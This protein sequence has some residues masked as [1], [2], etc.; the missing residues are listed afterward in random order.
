MPGQYIP[1]GY[2]QNMLRSRPGP[3]SIRHGVPSMFLTVL[4]S[5]AG[6]VCAPE[7]S[8]PAQ[9]LFSLLL[10]LRAPNMLWLHNLQM[11]MIHSC[12][13]IRHALRCPAASTEIAR[14]SAASEVLKIQHRERGGHQ[15]NPG[16]AGG[17]FLEAGTGGCLERNPIRGWS[18]PGGWRSGRGWPFHGCRAS[19]SG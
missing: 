15:V 1:R 4:L 3:A 12:F 14:T 13:A 19:A 6:S 8:Q 9:T 10:L 2:G 17:K 11:A 7:N 5:A 16:E 18:A